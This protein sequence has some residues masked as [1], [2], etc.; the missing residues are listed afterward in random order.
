[1]MNVPCRWLAE[2]VDIEITEEGIKRLAERLTL[3][4]LEV[5]EI[6][7]VPSVTGAFVGRVLSS[8]PH[9]NSDHLSLC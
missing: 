9:P 3:A 2:Y 8:A 1:M 7:C 4:G 6:I 5:E